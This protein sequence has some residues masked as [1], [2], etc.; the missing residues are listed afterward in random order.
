[1][2]ASNARRELPRAIGPKVEEDEGVAVF[3]RARL[4]DDRRHDELV[5]FAARVGGSRRRRARAAAR[6]SARRRRP[7]GRTRVAC[8]P[9]AGRDPSRSSVRQTLAIAPVRPRS[10]ELLSSRS[11]Y[12][13]AERGGVSRPSRKQCTAS[14]T[15]RRDRRIDQREEMLDRTVHAAVGEQPHEMQRS[16]GARDVRDALRAALRSSRTRPSRSRRR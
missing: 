13:S 12:C 4:A 6:C 14:G 8:A 15:P 9:S 10:R 5:V 11:T 16:A 3:D 7:A 2:P 1:M